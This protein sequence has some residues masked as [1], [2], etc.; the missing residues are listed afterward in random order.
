MSRFL[1][2]SRKWILFEFWQQYKFSIPRSRETLCVLVDGCKPGEAEKYVVH[3]YFVGGW[4]KP[5][6]VQCM[7]VGGKDEIKA[8]K[9]V[10]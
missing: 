2:T 10:S 1:S 7:F 5:K 6:N 4:S 9:I 8:E 3:M